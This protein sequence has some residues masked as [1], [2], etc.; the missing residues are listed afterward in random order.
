M[1]Q[2]FR[3]NSLRLAEYE[4]NTPGGYF[5]TISVE[6]MLQLFGKVHVHECNLNKA[7]LMIEQVLTDTVSN[8]PSIEI[9]VY[10]VMPN[11]VHM[12]LHL[13]DAAETRVKNKRSIISE[14]VQTFKSKSTVEYIRGIKILDWHKF[15]KRLWKRGYYDHIIR[16]DKDYQHIIMYIFNNPQAKWL[17]IEK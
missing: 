7:G 5:I 4:Y 6:N 15:N 9:I 1:D 13:L 17:K 10:T 16:N 12:L 8:F 11:H 14:F 2:R 3:K